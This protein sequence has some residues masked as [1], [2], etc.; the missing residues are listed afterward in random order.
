MKY[1]VIIHDAKVNNHKNQFQIL[2]YSQLNIWCNNVI[3][4]YIIFK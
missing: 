1:I 3:I 4:Q 2:Q